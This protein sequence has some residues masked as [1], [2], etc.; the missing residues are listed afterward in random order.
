MDVPSTVTGHG[1]LVNIRAVILN[2]R[3]AALTW[4]T[5]TTFSFAHVGCNGRGTEETRDM[6][7]TRCSVTA[8]MK[9]NIEQRKLSSS[10]S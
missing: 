3:D 9:S 6:L 5:S 2:H 4:A 1:E 7:P 8:L 10:L